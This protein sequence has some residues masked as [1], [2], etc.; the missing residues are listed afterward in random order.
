MVEKIFKDCLGREIKIG[1]V[2]AC[3][4]RQDSRGG[5]RVGIVTGFTEKTILVD[6]LSGDWWEHYHTR[7]NTSFEL[8]KGRFTADYNCCIIGLTKE[9]LLK[10]VNIVEAA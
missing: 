10:I 8:R 3:G 4:Q 9:E 2:L 5:I 6:I 1:H 7:R